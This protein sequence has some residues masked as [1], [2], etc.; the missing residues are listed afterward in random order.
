MKS[1]FLISFKAIQNFI[2][3]LVLLVQNDFW[4]KCLYFKRSVK[5][6]APFLTSVLSPY[7]QFLKTTA[8][9]IDLLKT[10][11]TRS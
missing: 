8:I 11:L 2:I 10:S 4:F 3:N 9:F 7:F 6:H 5:K 1:D